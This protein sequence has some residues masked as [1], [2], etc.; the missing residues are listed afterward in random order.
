LPTITP[1]PTVFVPEGEWTLLKPLSLEYP[2]YGPTE[3]E[4]VWEGSLPS[5]YGFEVR[6]WREGE[7]P[8][9]AHDA[10]LDNQQGRVKQI[11]ENEYRLSIDIRGADGV[12]GRTSQYLWTVAMVQISPHYARLDQQAEPARLRF[13]AGADSKGN[14]GSGGVGIE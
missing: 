2:S 12:R 13:E 3:F 9:G 1:T 11:G 7:L 14:G 6:V 5:N 4:W 8:L 10:V